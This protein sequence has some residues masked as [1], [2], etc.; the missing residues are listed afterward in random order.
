V[1]YV[2]EDRKQESLDGFWETLTEE[3]RNGIE[4]VATDMGMDMWDS[5]VASVREHVAD[6]DEKIVFDKF[7]VALSRLD[8][9]L[10]PV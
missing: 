6:A 10:H 9:L 4:A 3:Q 5:Y 7:H 2:A 1:L 8:R